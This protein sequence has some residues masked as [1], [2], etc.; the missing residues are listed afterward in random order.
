MAR[1]SKHYLDPL[2]SSVDLTYEQQMSRDCVKTILSDGNNLIAIA[3]AIGKVADLILQE[4]NQHRGP[5]GKESR[6]YNV[7]R[8]EH[9]LPREFRAQNASNYKSY[10]RATFRLAYWLDAQPRWLHCDPPLMPI[11][12][13][14]SNL[15]FDHLVV[16]TRQALY[17]PLDETDVFE[18]VKGCGKFLRAAA[19]QQWS[20]K[21]LESE[22]QKQAGR[23]SSGRPKQLDIPR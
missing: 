20:P 9:A 10:G 4:H 12:D 23:Q 22:I 1:T 5:G 2:V 11:A 7:L 17:K 19:A 8:W 14:F 18:I 15:T 13:K 16:L 6:D 21:K 3:K